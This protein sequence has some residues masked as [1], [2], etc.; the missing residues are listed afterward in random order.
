MRRQCRGA[1]MYDSHGLEHDEAFWL[2]V[3]SGEMQE[4]LVG[5]PVTHLSEVCGGM[6]RAA[7]KPPTSIRAHAAAV[8]SRSPPLSSGRTDSFLAL[9]TMASR[10]MAGRYSIQKRQRDAI[11]MLPGDM[12]LGLNN[13]DTWGS[14]LGYHIR[15]SQSLGRSCYMLHSALILMRI[16]MDNGVV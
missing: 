16:L 2:D 13:K 7:C 1:G 6:Q 14:F 9:T 12:T 4:G 15:R 5:A 3:W 8:V 10:N 11:L